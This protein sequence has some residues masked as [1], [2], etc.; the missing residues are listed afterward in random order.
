[1]KLLKNLF[2]NQTFITNTWNPHGPTIKKVLSG[3]LE[4]DPRRRLSAKAALRIL[5]V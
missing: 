4:V 3:L 2:L 1:L 5:A